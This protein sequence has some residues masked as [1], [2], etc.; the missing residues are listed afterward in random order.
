MKELDLVR[1]ICEF[2]VALAEAL[3]AWDETPMEDR[4]IRQA[5]EYI[6]LLERMVAVSKVDMDKLAANGGI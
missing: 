2:T 6:Q 3:A 1:G 4:T 5:D